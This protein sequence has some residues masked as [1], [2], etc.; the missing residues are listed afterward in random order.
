MKCIQN[1]NLFTKSINLWLYAF[2]PGV[3]WLNFPLPCV[4]NHKYLIL[5]GKT[6]RC[7]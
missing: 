4:N 1:E 6:L 7:L 2:I 3:I 5:P